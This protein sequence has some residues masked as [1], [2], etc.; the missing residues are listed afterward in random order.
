MVHT[1]LE[2]GPDVVRVGQRINLDEHD[3]G[4]NGPGVERVGVAAVGRFIKG[5]PEE[6]RP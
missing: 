5:P 2:T 6:R 1:C 4:E 3:F